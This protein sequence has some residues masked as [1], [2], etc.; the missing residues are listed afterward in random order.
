MISAYIALMLFFISY[1]YI[2]LKAVQQLAVVN[3]HTRWIVPT[4]LCLAFCE[5]TTITVLAVNKSIWYFPFIGLGAGAGALTTMFFYKK[6]KNKNIDK[7][8]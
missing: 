6:I 3:F 8:Y 4:S 7:Q 5:V 1:V 2:A